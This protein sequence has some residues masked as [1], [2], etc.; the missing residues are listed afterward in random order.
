[1]LCGAS[2]TENVQD[3]FAEV[4]EGFGGEAW[5]YLSGRIQYLN[6]A[7]ASWERNSITSVQEADVCVFV[8]IDRY[9]VVTWEKEL[10]AALES[11]RP[12]LVFCFAKTYQDYRTLSSKV[13]DLAV[14]DENGQ[15]LVRLL[16]DLESDERQLTVVQFRYNDFAKKLRSHFGT[17]IERLLRERTTTRPAARGTRQ[18]RPTAKVFLSHSYRS[19]EINLRF[20]DKVAELTDLRFEVDRKGLRLS[21]TRLERLI[22]NTDYFVGFYPL[23]GDLETMSRDDLVRSATYFQLELEMAARARKPAIAFIDQRYQSVLNPP[24]GVQAVKYS[25]QEALSDNDQLVER[26]IQR[27][28]ADFLLRF[29]GAPRRISVDDGASV[30]I[31]VP[32]ENAHDAELGAIVVES[33]ETRGR[34][35]VLVPIPPAMDDRFLARLRECDSVVL[36][37]DHPAAPVVAAYL[38]GQA[39]P[40]LRL[41]HGPEPETPEPDASVDTLLFGGQARHYAKDVVYWDDVETLHARVL[42]RAERIFAEPRLMD[43][44]SKARGYFEAAAQLPMPVFL[45]YAD[46]DHDVAAALALVLRSRFTEVL[47]VVDRGALR[48]RA[49]TIS[50]LDRADVAITLLTRAYADAEDCR[51]EARLIAERHASWQLRVFAIQVENVRLDLLGNPKYRRADASWADIVNDIVQELRNRPGSG[52]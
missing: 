12:F 48:Q 3:D 13:S 45:S 15:R 18:R 39:V 20:F 41:R 17:L 10:H 16:R 2:D 21:T 14:L 31:L 11:G 49:R 34:D 5:H 52:S 36:S 40:T 32:T 7:N 27:P 26:A 44:T 6:D 38:R 42:D 25:A 30:G 28:F 8:L 4:V 51:E 43:T 23:R 22:R 19:P 35:T 29:E 47:N 33:I 1:M 37:M 24:R 9:G 46:D 50:D